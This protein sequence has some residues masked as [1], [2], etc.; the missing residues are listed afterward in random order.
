M[1][2]KEPPIGAPTGKDRLDEA[3]F[4]ENIAH[5][6]RN[7]ETT[8][9]NI[10]IQAIKDFATV[11]EITEIKN[12]NAETLS[13]ITQ[14]VQEWNNSNWEFDCDWDNPTIAIKKEGELDKRQLRADYSIHWGNMDKTAA[15]WTA[16]LVCSNRDD[17][18][19]GEIGFAVWPDPARYDN[20][21][22]LIKP[23]G[24]VQPQWINEQGTLIIFPSILEWG[25][26]AVISGELVLCRMMFSGVGWK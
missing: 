20:Y 8:H 4:R 19:G 22:N 13:L 5:G 25:H 26:R 23:A 15:K 11:D 16:L 9:T 2:Y 10:A 6:H 7:H 12:N 14:Q 1:E 24:N 3:E 17:V 21:G 18:Q